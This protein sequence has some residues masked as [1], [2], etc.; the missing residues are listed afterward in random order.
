VAPKGSHEI[1]FYLAKVKRIPIISLNLRVS[2]T[3]RTLLKHYKMSKVGQISLPNIFAQIVVDIGFVWPLDWPG[4][5]K[6]T[7]ETQ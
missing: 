6:T 1:H 2:D 5:A 3:T 7:I 4:N